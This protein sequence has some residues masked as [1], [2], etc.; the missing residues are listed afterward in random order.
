VSV[1]VELKPPPTSH[2]RTVRRAIN[3]YVRRHDLR[4]WDATAIGRVDRVVKEVFGRTLLKP[5]DVRGRHRTLRDAVVHDGWPTLGRVRGKVFVVLNAEEKLRDVYRKG[6]PSLQ[7]R[8]MFVV[9]SP[10]DASAAVIS[11]DEPN[12]AEFRRLVR[13]HF[14]VRTRADAEGLEAR[15][16]DHARA[17]MAF[18]SGATMVA[19]DYPVPDPAVNASFV[20]RLP[21]RVVARCNPVTAPKACTDSVLENPKALRERP[22]RG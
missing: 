9:S 15:D 17:T 3:A 12:P 6:A 21:G 11:R 16:N 13:E 2:N 10:Q 7:R 14:L 19:T 4:K 8:S 18:A 22:T 1:F 20:V 5:D